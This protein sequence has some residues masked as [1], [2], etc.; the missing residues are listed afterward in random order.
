MRRIEFRLDMR[1]GEEY[2]IEGAWG[3]RVRGQIERGRTPEGRRR[4]CYYR[5][6]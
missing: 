5:C 1:I 6:F 4:A 2:K 3:L